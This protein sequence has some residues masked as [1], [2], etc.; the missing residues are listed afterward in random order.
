[1]SVQKYRLYKNEIPEAALRPRVL[2]APLRLAVAGV[3]GGAGQAMAGNPA[4]RQVFPHVWCD[5]WSSVMIPSVLTGIESVVFGNGFRAP[6]CF[7]GAA[8][9]ATYVPSFPPALVTEMG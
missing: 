8:H 6:P 4:H 7:N 1:M 2:L 9:K 3:D 5:L